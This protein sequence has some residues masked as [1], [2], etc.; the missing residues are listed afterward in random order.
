M[1]MVEK[2]FP[3]GRRRVETTPSIVIKLDVID[4]QGAGD[5]PLGRLFIFYGHNPGRITIDDSDHVL[6]QVTVHEGY[7]A[8]TIPR[9]W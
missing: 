9:V 5:V 4:G 1:S 8:A 7:H 3:D 6:L 2:L